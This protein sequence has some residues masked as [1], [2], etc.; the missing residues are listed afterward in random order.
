[1]EGKTKRQTKVAVRLQ[2][3]VKTAVLFINLVYVIDGGEIFNMFVYQK[4][5]RHVGIAHFCKPSIRN[6][7]CQCFCSGVVYRVMVIESCSV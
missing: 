6:V 5:E 4:L 7:V 2:T 3:D 1:M